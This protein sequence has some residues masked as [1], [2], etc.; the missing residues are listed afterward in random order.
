MGAPEISK[1]SSALI[2]LV[3]LECVAH[4][5]FPLASSCGFCPRCHVFM[6]FGSKGYSLSE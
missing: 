5:H 6:S 2:V 1:L 3:L 4:T